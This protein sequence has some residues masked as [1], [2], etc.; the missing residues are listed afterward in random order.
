[1][2][3]MI[4][5]IRGF[6]TAFPSFTSIDEIMDCEFTFSLKMKSVLS[7]AFELQFTMFQENSRPFSMTSVYDHSQSII[8]QQDQCFFFVNIPMKAIITNNLAIIVKIIE[9]R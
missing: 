3:S 9:K 5:M 7:P 2:K 6:N 8:A 4:N 1:M